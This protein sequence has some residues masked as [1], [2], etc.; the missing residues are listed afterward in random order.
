[1]THRSFYYNGH[2]ITLFKFVLR[3]EN[4]EQFL[5]K[6]VKPG[7]PWHT[8]PLGLFFTFSFLLCW[9]SLAR[10]DLDL[11]FIFN[12]INRYIQE[13]RVPDYLTFW[14]FYCPTP[15]R[16]FSSSFHNTWNDLE[17]IRK[18]FAFKKKMLI[19]NFNLNIWMLSLKR[20]GNLSFYFCLLWLENKNKRSIGNK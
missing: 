4:W 12:R 15:E 14:G 10:N 19:Y 6:Y 3:Y 5:G 16:T 9:Y 11:I 13:P 7:L 2:S 20:K 17:K 1:M 18:D 8:Y